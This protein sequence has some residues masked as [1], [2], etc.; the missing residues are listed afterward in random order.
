MKINFYF[1]SSHDMMDDQ[2]LKFIF[3]SESSSESKRENSGDESTD[4]EI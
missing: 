4:E 2:I 1:E 3:L